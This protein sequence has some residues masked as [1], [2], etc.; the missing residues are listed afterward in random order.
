[1]AILRILDISALRTPEIW[2]CVPF[3]GVWGPCG[4]LGF[5]GW[6]GRVAHAL[7]C[8]QNR[9]LGLLDVKYDL[10]LGGAVN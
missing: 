10:E 5:L 1:M 3:G 4:Y 8:L 9:F 6:G 7:K 2:P